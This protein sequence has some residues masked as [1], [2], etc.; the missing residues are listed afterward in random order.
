MKRALYVSLS[1]LAQWAL[2]A[3]LLFS[4]FVKAADPMGMEHKLEAYI[5]VLTYYMPWAGEWFHAGTIYLHIPVVALALFEFLLGVNMFLGVHQ[6]FST[7]ATTLF[8]TAMTL[9]TAWIYA[10][11]PVPDC[12]CFGDAIT[13]TNGQTLVK[14][15][16]LL[17]CAI[18]LLMHRKYMVRFIGRGS[19]WVPTNSSFIYIIALS[20][21]SLWFLP[22]VDFTG[23]KEG[24]DINTALMG[25]YDT[26]YTYAPDGKT[27][28][29]AESV[30]LAAPTIE[31]FS[32]TDA[33][34]NDLAEEILCDSSYTFIL[35]LP[36]LVTADK[37]CSDQLNDVYDFC[38]DNHLRMVCA[39]T[40]TPDERDE[41]SD[42][43]GAA[44]PF[45]EASAEML[46]AMV[47]SNPGLLLI[48]NGKIIKKWG[49]HQMPQQ[50]EL[51]LEALQAKTR[52]TAEV[53]SAA[54]TYAVL[55]LIYIGLVCLVIITT[56]IRRALRIRKAA[57]IKKQR[58]NL[59][60]NPLK[61]SQQ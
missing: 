12:G 22:L 1:L 61:I 33:G 59:F 36:T 57:K 21:Y 14:N 48:H 26:Q 30:Q 56:N 39:T 9:V 8:I 3:T 37:G 54:S 18:A 38:V 25:E 27:V 11:D 29:S 15:L 35:T 2:A 7:A 47:R 43:T 42:R 10:Y 40:L 49:H 5:R 13:L 32:M 16:V 50:E 55:S 45:A 23:Y 46:E 17:A 4:G 44:Y 24:T 28:L 52:H 58:K 60:I 6:R 20:A 41:W 53:S 34:G 51:T 31:E 19:E